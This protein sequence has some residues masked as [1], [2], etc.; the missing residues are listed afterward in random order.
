M[1]CSGEIVDK[2][3]DDLI[4]IRPSIVAQLKKTMTI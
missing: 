2:D 3:D 1:S 4:Q